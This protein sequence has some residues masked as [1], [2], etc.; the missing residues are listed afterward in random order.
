MNEPLRALE[1][2]ERQVG[3]NDAT[4][5]LRAVLSLHHPVSQNEFAASPVPDPVDVCAIDCTT[6]YPCDTARAIYRHLPEEQQ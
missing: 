1:R 2:Y 4:A 3:E 5:A 6:A